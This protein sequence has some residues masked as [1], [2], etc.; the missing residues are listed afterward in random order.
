VPV[1][2]G[3][4]GISCQWRDGELRRGSAP[5]LVRLYIGEV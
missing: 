4:F 5:R 3:Y 2:A 1:S